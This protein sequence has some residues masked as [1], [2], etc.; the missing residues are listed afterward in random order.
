[1]VEHR[2][3]RLGEVRQRRTR[4]RNV[5]EFGKKLKVKN[6]VCEP[7]QDSLEMLDNLAMVV[8]RFSDVVTEFASA[9][10]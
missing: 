6:I 8:N 2:Q 9:A 10:P 1:M 7:S 4:P 5:F 3:L